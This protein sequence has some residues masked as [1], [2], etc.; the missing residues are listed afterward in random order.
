MNYSNKKE[1]NSNHKVM[2]DTTN[3]SYDP[4]NSAKLRVYVYIDDHFVHKTEIYG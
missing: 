3:R 2:D 1:E 4:N